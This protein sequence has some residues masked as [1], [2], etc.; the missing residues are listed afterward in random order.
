[1]FSDAF[2]LPPGFQ[3][4]ATSRR[5]VYVPTFV[6]SQYRGPSLFVFDF[7]SLAAVVQAEAHHAKTASDRD[8][9]KA[10]QCKTDSAMNGVVKV[11]DRL[12]QALQAEL[13]MTNRAREATQ[14]PKWGGG[15]R[16]RK[17][18]FSFHLYTPFAAVQGNFAR[19]DSCAH[20]ASTRYKGVPSP[21]LCLRHKDDVREDAI[22]LLRAH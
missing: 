15:K 12:I 3:T 13:D 1:M 19:R 6:H 17:A 14:V 21:R 9:Q 7:H 22:P 4:V 18:Q 16:G 20:T 2:G 8:A 5:L 11:Q 10:A